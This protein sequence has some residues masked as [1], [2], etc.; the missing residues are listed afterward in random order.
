MRRSLP[1]AALVAAFTAAVCA[2]GWACSDEPTVRREVL[3]PTTGAGGTLQS[4]AADA[5]LAVGS[6]VVG[7]SDDEYKAALLRRRE[8]LRGS[9]EAIPPGSATDQRSRYE[10]E[11]ELVQEK[12]ED[13]TKAFVEQ[14]RLEQLA[15]AAAELFLYRAEAESQWEM[16]YALRSGELSL[17]RSIIHD[18][19]SRLQHRARLAEKPPLPNEPRPPMPAAGL[20]DVKRLAGQAFSALAKLAESGADFE[21]AERAYRFAIEYSGDLGV[22]AD[23]MGGYAELLRTLGRDAE[24]AKIDAQRAELLSRMVP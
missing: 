18:N 22:S 24:A 11:L 14:Q 5:D 4:V 12:L 8:E 17:A 9:L 7:G 3:E 2:A 10:R 15:V 23:A 6:A 20:D 19:L 21:E 16:T 1:N 13:S